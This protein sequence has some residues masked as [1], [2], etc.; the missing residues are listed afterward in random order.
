MKQTIIFFLLLAFGVSSYCQAPGTDYTKDYYLQK[1]KN[2]KTIAWVMLAGGTGLAI[3]GLAIASKQV[4][5]NPA[6]YFFTVGKS[7]GST[8][9]F[10]IGAG[11]AIGSIPL[12][13]QSKKNKNRAAYMSFKNQEIMIPQQNGFAA[14][15]QPAIVLKIG[16]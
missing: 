15:M 10:L 13:I 5:D 11:A 7:V 8:V 12:F 14:K 6:D 4:N 2:Q 9:V 16:L 3:T 1:S